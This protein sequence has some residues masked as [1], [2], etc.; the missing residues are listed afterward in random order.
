[1]TVPRKVMTATM[2]KRIIQNVLCVPRLISG[3]MRMLSRKGKTIEPAPTAPSS[4]MLTKDAS[5]LR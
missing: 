2:M 5:T 1:M 4:A 3:L